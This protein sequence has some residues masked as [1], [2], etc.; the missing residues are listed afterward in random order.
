MGGFFSK[1][2]SGGSTKTDRKTQLQGFGDLQN[3][4]N[5]GMDTSKQQLGAGQATTAEGLKTLQD[6]LKYWKTLLTGDRTAMA[7]AIAP[8]ANAVQ[9]AADAAKQQRGA[10]GTARGGGTAGINATAQDRVQAE[11]DNLLFGLRPAAAGQVEKIGG[12][13]ANIGLKEID[14]ALGF[15]GLG[16]DAARSITGL[17]GESRKTS[18]DMNKDIAKRA[19]GMIQSILG[20]FF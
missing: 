13:F 18:Y 20:G 8:E 1:L 11:L 17:A 6:P 19:G 7:G 10:M 2:F 12:E 14:Q 3:I 9:T 4:F 5:F 16:E 15:A